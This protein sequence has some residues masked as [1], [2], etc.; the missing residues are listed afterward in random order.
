MAF[1]KASRSPNRRCSIA[2]TALLTL[3]SRGR[4]HAIGKQAVLRP[5]HYTHSCTPAWHPRT[6][7]LRSSK[8]PQQAL[9]P[10]GGTDAHARIDTVAAAA[11][12]I[13]SMRARLSN[14]LGHWEPA[15]HERAPATHRAGIQ[16]PQL[17]QAAGSQPTPDGRCG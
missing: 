5:S 6:P 13:C 17:R 9:A 11:K 7:G 3:A 15:T 16:A 12:P 14:G 4:E 2:T 1:R 10:A 8:L